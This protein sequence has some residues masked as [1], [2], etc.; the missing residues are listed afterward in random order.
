MLV[1]V[2]IVGL[3]VALS[4]P[5]ARYTFVSAVAGPRFDLLSSVLFGNVYVPTVSSVPN[6]SWNE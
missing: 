4:N 1:A 3:N 6:C 5:N 2:L